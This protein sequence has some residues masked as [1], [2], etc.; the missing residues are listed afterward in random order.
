MT[1]PIIIPSDTPKN[2][3]H[4][5]ASLHLDE[6]AKAVVV[7]SSLPPQEEPAQW[8][9][10]LTRAEPFCYAASVN[11][12]LET[13]FNVGC[14][15]VIVMNDDCT[16]LTP[17]GLSGMVKYLNT[18]PGPSKLGLISAVIKGRVGLHFQALGYHKPA[19][20][21]GEKTVVQLDERLA[22]PCVA[23]SRRLWEK[24]GPLDE[25]FTGYGYDDD[26]YSR[27]ALAA[28]FGTGVYTG[29]IVEH[30]GP[31]QDSTYW[32]KHQDCG[33]LMQQNMELYKKKWKEE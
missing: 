6:T 11:H 16:L 3:A 2:L 13:V 1:T 7:S 28:G 14:K 10:W 12:A 19:I 17:N 20:D 27:R 24:I 15:G 9:L 8:L 25:Q 26:D 23:I 29:C 32:S 5:I 4:C 30:P 33:V 31:G 21:R 22:F 18:S